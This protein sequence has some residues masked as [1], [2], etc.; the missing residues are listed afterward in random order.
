MQFF[1]HGEREKSVTIIVVWQ[2]FLY[3]KMKFHSY[4][5]TSWLEEFRNWKYFFRDFDVFRWCNSSTLVG[6]CTHPKDWLGK[7]RS[8]RYYWMHFR[9]KHEARNKVNM[10]M[11]T[12]SDHNALRGDLTS[13]FR[14]I[15]MEWLFWILETYQTRLKDHWIKKSSLKFTP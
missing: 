10:K 9:G 1:E 6:G 4:F 3:T 15:H 12:Q 5:C 14:R 2:L 8:I 7:N 13:T 11:R